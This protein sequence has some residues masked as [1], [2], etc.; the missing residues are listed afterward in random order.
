MINA[1]DPNEFLAM[2]PQALLDECKS[3]NIPN[4]QVIELA[5]TLN[6]LRAG[7]PLSVNVTISRLNSLDLRNNRYT[8]LN[9]SRTF[10]IRYS[11]HN[12]HK[13]TNDWRVDILEGYNYIVSKDGVITWTICKAPGKI[14]PLA[15]KEFLKCKFQGS[16][17]SAINKLDLFYDRY[18]KSY[19]EIYQREL[20]KY[21]EQVCV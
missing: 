4:R 18:I 7:I 3:Y 9:T 5:S 8:D 1:I 17:M 11:R 6:N 16:N 21:E 13:V 14:F 19:N 10:L 12:L 20:A 15:Y 2:V